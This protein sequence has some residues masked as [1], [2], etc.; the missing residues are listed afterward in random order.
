MS[1]KQFLNESDDKLLDY[2]RGKGP[3]PMDLFPRGS[4]R[5]VGTVYR[6]FKVDW[7]DDV[8]KIFGTIPNLNGSYTYNRPPYSAWSKSLDSA[9]TF[10]PYQSNAHEFL[11]TLECT[12]ASMSILCDFDAVSI[13][14][15][16]KYKVEQEVLLT[17]PLKVK[18]IGLKKPNEKDIW[19]R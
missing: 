12:P 8:E 7:A 9:R 5:P 3:F 15:E 4:F 19:R 17:G 14:A 16:K 13:Y 1:F 2:L 11:F 6:V 10:E 18:V